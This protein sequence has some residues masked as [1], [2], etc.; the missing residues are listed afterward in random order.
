MSLHT[1]IVEIY[2]TTEG[3]Q[4]QLK[5]NRVT[6]RYHINIDGLV[7]ETHHKREIKRVIN[8]YLDIESVL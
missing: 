5:F 6:L 2:T 1:K 8:N 7:I 4:Y 3:K